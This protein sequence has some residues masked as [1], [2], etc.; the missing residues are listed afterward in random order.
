MAKMDANGNELK[1]VKM[2]HNYEKWHFLAIF[3]IG[4]SPKKANLVISTMKSA[5]YGM[6]LSGGKKSK[7]LKKVHRVCHA[8]MKKLMGVS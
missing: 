1:V 8:P 7:I 6:R 5:I 3:F 2:A 4:N